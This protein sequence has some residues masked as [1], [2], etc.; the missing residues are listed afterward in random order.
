VAATIS[1][2]SVANVGSCRS[3]MNTIDVVAGLILMGDQLLV[4]QRRRDGAFPLKWE[5]PG[6]K[7]EIG[8][9]HEAALVRELKEEL[10]I[11]VRSVKEIFRHQQ[12]YPGAATVNLRFYRVGAFSGMVRNLVFQNI[13]WLTWPELSQ[14][15]LLE[16]DL[17]LVKH[18]MSADGRKLLV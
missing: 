2:S 15:D 11:E 17:P 8:E 3:N 5:F 14:L 1:A 10:G 4:C 9:S 6:G 12:A 7:V 18:L 16:G 13:A